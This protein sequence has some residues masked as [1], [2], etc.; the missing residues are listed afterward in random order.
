MVS[1]YSGFRTL[2]NPQSE[3]IP[4]SSQVPNNAGG[5][6]F[7]VDD[8]MRL[9]RFLIL[10]SEKGTYYVGETAL[11]RENAAA[12]MRCL[13]EDGA[14]VV[15]RVVEVSDSGRAPKNDPA[16]FVLAMAAGLGSPETRRAALAALPHVCRIGTH[17]LHFARPWGSTPPPW[18][19]GSP[20]RS[21][22]AALACTRW[23]SCPR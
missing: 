2:A 19:P 17:L 1:A 22:C 23:R 14:R 15:R 12:V 21:S 8:W 20:I 5:F 3:A 10:G 18:W 13:A 4:G 11:T 16:I 6:A 7:P 9:D